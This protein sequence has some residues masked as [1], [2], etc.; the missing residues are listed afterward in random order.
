MKVTFGIFIPEEFVNTGH[1]TGGFEIT[2]DI[3]TQARTY[4]L[5]KV[6][7]VQT[8]ELIGLSRFSEH[9]QRVIFANAMNTARKTLRQ[10]EEALEEEVADKRREKLE[11]K[12]L[13]RERE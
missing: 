11:A 12:G 1:P 10:I 13:W 7:D 3:D 9:W 6:W 5:E 4:A 8:G 2:M